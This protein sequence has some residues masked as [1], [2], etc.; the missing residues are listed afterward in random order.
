MSVYKRES[1]GRWVGSVELGKDN[2]GK[3]KQKT[4]YGKTKKEAEEKINKI[5]YEIATGQYQQ[6]TKGTLISFLRDYYSVCEPK[7][8][9]TTKSLYKMYIDVHFEPYFESMKLTDIKPITLDKFY[10]YKLTETRKIKVVKK[11]KEED[12]IIKPLSVNTVRKLNT[13]LK[14]AFNYAVNNK[15]VKENPTNFVVLPKKTKY[16]PTVFNVE[17]FI[18]LLDS[19]NGDDDEV[20]I[21]LGGG[22][23]LRRGEIFG[24]RWKDIDFDNQTITIERTTVRFD[25]I[26]EKATAKNETS[27]RTI[28]APKQVMEVLKRHKDKLVNPKQNDKVIT[29]WKPTTY[30]ERYRSLLDRHKLPDCRLHDLRHYNAVIL[31]NRGIPDKV[32][33]ERLGHSQVST[34]RDVYQ[35]VMKD[36]DETAAS[37]LDEMF[38]TKKRHDPG[39]E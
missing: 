29:Q 5:K 6:S 19:V 3:R 34:L 25:K 37:E 16:K 26:I 17:Q 22:C 36:M 12:K 14:A 2:R 31:M 15:L 27:Q 28:V 35:H 11:G 18:K 7:W 9:E 32:A 33:A 1:D 39:E 20:P 23:G 30:S 21:I 4:V 38:K 10:K 8:E 24:L 13:F